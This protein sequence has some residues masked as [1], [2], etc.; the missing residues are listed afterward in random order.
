MDYQVMPEL[1]AEE[2]SDL[3]ADIQERGVMIPIEFDEFG[4]VLDG[5][6]RLKI[7]QELGIKNYPKVIRAGM[8]ESEKLTHARKLNIALRHLTSEQKRGLIREQ[9][10][11][12]PGKSDRQ[13]A[14][15]LGVSHPTVAAQRRELE[16]SGDVEKFT[17]STDTLGREQPRIR[18]PVSVFNPSPSRREEKALSNPEVISRMQNSSANPVTISKQLLSEA[19]AE[20]KSYTLNETMPDDICKLFVDDIRSGLVKIQDNSV[21]FIITDPPYERKY[22]SLYSYL[23]GVARR[24]LKNGGSLIVMTGQSY[25]PEVISH[26]SEAMNYYWCMTYLTLG[27]QATQLFQ[28]RVNT[29]WKPVL[30]YVKN[31]YSGDF[32]SDIL[33]SPENDKNFHKWGQSFGGMSDIIEKLTNPN[34]LILDPF[35]GGGTT[36]A[37]AVSMGR[38]FIG[39]DIE[40]KNIEISRERIKECYYNAR[41]SS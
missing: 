7:C 14:Q 4:Q 20:R 1:T 9:L 2:Y 16:E 40:A 26:L 24:V 28:K 31:N 17:T 5:H 33:R 29:F 39:V 21:D 32:T 34:D 11:E 27:N 15:A 36:G 25:L 3:K 23:S 37:A 10:I 13:I 12:T 6:H 19:K 22:L 38:K 30:W 8:S 41:A 18:K 35:L